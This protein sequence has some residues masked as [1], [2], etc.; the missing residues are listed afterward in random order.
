MTKGSKSGMRKEIF[1]FLFPHYL[2]PGISAKCN[3]GA[4]KTFFGWI[5]PDL[6]QVT[7][8]KKFFR[9]QY[10]EDFAETP[11]TRDLP[12]TGKKKLWKSL[13]PVRFRCM[14]M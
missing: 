10:C 7:S 8:Q 13:C 12:G 4:G 3:I 9:H 11:S 5:P 1:F 14:E 6:S 2:V